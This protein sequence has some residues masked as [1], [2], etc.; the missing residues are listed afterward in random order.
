MIAFKRWKKLKKMMETKDR[1]KIMAAN[2]NLNNITKP[3]AERI[4][5]IAIA[6]TLQGK[7]I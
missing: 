6:K 2:E 5:D 1:N 7:N 4:M 3:F